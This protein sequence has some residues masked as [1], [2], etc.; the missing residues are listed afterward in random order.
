MQDFPGNSRKAQERSDGPRQ[1]ERPKIEQ[2]TSATAERRKPGLGRKFRDTF[3][4]GTARGAAEYVITDVL[5]PTI[6]DLLFEG[7][8]SGFEKW[9][10]GE[11]RVRRGGGSMSSGYSSVGHVN[12]AGMSS[13][14]PSTTRSLSQSARARHDFGEIVIHNRQEAEEVL[15][16]LYEELSRYGQVNVAVLYELTGIQSSHAD[17]NWGWNSLRGAK[18]ARLPRSGGWLLDLPEPEPLG[19]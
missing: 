14:K 12:Y 4:S 16:R 5:V 9:V 3:I 10:Y 7:V 11:S 15:D 19:R 18:I 13:N 1:E 17:H 8:Q 2:V 6:R